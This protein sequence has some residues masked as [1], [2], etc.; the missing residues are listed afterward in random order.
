[1][2]AERNIF[3]LSDSRQQSTLVRGGDGPAA[4]GIGGGGTRESC[5]YLMAALLQQSNAIGV[6]RHVVAQH[7][8]EFRRVAGRHVYQHGQ[9]GPEVRQPRVRVDD[10]LRR[11]FVGRG[12]TRRDCCGRGDASGLLV[13]LAQPVGRLQQRHHSRF[14][15]FQLRV[16]VLR[17]RGKNRKKKNKFNFTVR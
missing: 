8:A 4:A 14:A 7:R 17:R 3:V 12:A 11:L 9:P 10:D 6:R 2:T 1:M 16:Q 5:V 15:P 13:G